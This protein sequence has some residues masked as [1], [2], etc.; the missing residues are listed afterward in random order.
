VE[1]L[2]PELALHVVLG[3]VIGTFIGMTGIGGGVLVQPALIHLLGIPPVSAVGTGL[4]FAFLVKAG[5]VLSHIRL[6][7]TCNRRAGLYLGGAV[8]GLLISSITVNRLAR[9]LDAV[10]VNRVVEV[11]IGWVLV[12]TAAILAVEALVARGKKDDSLVPAVGGEV[13]RVPRPGWG[14]VAGLVTGVLVGATSVSGGVLTLP[15]LILL[16]GA[17]PKQAVGTSILI[18]V[19]LAA[20][21]GSVYVISGN[22]VPRTALLMFLGGLPGVVLGSRISVRIGVSHLRVILVIMVTLCG[23]SFFVGTP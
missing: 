22:I 6:K 5:G 7:T 21:G 15:A 17:H 8:P 19:V 1:G 3:F 2:I 10:R 18:S 23:L 11:G 20:L 12:L 13:F 9:S 4:A 14:V 16:L